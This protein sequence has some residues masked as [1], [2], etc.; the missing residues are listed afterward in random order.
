M[1]KRVMTSDKELV[2][3]REYEIFYTNRNRS[4]NNSL[5]FK[6][7]LIYLTDSFYVFKGDK[8]NTSF[9]IVDFYINQYKLRD[10]V[11]K[12]LIKIVYKDI[13]EDEM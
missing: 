11:T 5:C 10:L 6:G 13:L 9:L 1:I 7:E 8:Y 2:I 12:Q 4:K 3:G